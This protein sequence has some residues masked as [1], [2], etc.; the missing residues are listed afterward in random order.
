LITPEIREAEHQLKFR[1]RRRNEIALVQ[2]ARFVVEK[3]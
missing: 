3:K 2:S 1:D